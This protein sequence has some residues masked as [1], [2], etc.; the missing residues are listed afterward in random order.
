LSNNEFPRRT[1]PKKKGEED[2]QNEKLRRDAKPRWG[3]T[4]YKQRNESKGSAKK[5]SEQRVVGK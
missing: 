1:E 5:G 3:V 4:A 2:A